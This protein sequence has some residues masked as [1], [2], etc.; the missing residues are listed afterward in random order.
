MDQDNLTGV[1]EKLA[2]SAKMAE[3]P[4]S[5]QQ[6]KFAAEQEHQI[7]RLRNRLDEQGVRLARLEE[8]TNRFVGIFE[9]IVT[10]EIN[11]RM[12]LS[13]NQSLGNLNQGKSPDVDRSY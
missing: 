10:D 6:S 13:S 11:R 8:K 3:V 12:Y 5:Y 4:W 2:D 7:K 1:A 9:A